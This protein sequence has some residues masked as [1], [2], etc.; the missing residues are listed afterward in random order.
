MSD[1]IAVMNQG[2]LVEVGTAE[3]VYHEPKD[4]YTKALLRGR[5]RPRPARQRERKPSGPSAQ[6]ERRLA[7]RRRIRLADA[8]RTSRPALGTA[9]RLGFDRRRTFLTSRSAIV[10]VDMA[11]E[12][13][14]LRNGRCER[15]RQWASLRIDGE[16][17][18]LEDALLEKHLE[19]C[20]SCSAFAVRLAATTEAVRAVPLERT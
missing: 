2:K 20:A 14:S 19:G 1:R 13:S 8:A 12:A 9:G 4:E 7:P 16:L 15:A 6:G 17:S 10:R 5:A 3:Q 18:E 11:G